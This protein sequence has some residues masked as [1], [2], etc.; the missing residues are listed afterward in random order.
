MLTMMFYSFVLLLPALSVK[1]SV[2][3]RQNPGFQSIPATANPPGQFS[4]GGPELVGLPPVVGDT[5]PAIYGARSIDLPF[6]RMYHGNLKFFSPGQLNTA[7]GITDQWG[8]SNDNANQSACGIPD[9]AWKVSKVAI[10][11]YFLKYADLSRYCMQD[12]CISFWKDDGTSDMM[13]KVTDICST[14]PSDPTY[15]ASPADIK[16]DRAKAAIMEG[17]QGNPKAPEVSGDQYGEKVWWFFMKCWADG[18]AQPAYQNKQNWFTNPPLP[19]NLDWAQA[20]ATQQWKNN[21]A[22]YPA[23]GWETYP[24]GG[25]NTVRDDTTS[26][27]ISDWNAGSEPSWSPVAGGLGWG[28]GAGSSNGGSPVIETS[29]N[30]TQPGSPMVDPINT[31]DA[32]DAVSTPTNDAGAVPTT[33][34]SNYANAEGTS[35]VD[36]SPPAPKSQA[37][38][39]ASDSISADSDPSTPI[40]VSTAS[41]DESLGDDEDDEVCDS[42]YDTTNEAPF[43]SAGPA[44][45]GDASFNGSLEGIPVPAQS[46]PSTTADNTPTDAAAVAAADVLSTS[47]PYTFSAAPT[48]FPAAQN[49][50]ASSPASQSGTANAQNGGNGTNTSVPANSSSPSNTRR[51]APSSSSPDI[52][53]AVVDELST[54]FPYTFTAAPTTFPAGQNAP[55]SSPIADPASGSPSSGSDESDGAVSAEPFLSSSTTLAS[56]PANAAAA[57]A[58]STSFP[59]TFSAA[60]TTFPAAQNAGAAAA[61]DALSTTFPYTFS[62]APTTFPAF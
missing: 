38:A 17:H 25:Y 37:A 41:S 3:R 60:P 42:S 44:A 24:N 4:N 52:I 51:I 7:D 9:N 46:A 55:A 33:T 48:T 27:P 31:S 28:T 10:H 16:I 22:A 6:Y 1:A 5:P 20:A 32:D 13:L 23:K 8:A 49:S 59:Y 61:A 12:V 35:S 56:V 50:A 62:A 29:S 47:F 34:R 18:I 45:S 30:D 26:P 54:T 57:N 58:L 11:P 15:C 36:N 21:Q 40:S 39:G 53:A 2:I 14:D 19:N 43:D